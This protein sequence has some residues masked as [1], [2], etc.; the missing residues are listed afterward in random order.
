VVTDW[1]VYVFRLTFPTGDAGTYLVELQPDPVRPRRAI[2]LQLG[3]ASVA[4]IERG[5][6]MAQDQNLIQENSSLWERVQQVIAAV[7]EGK[8][9]E[10]AV[11]EVGVS[12]ELVARLVEMG[13]RSPFPAAELSL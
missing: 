4:E 3:N 12:A 1:G 11:A 7:R 10:A 6:N 8:T 2:A 9:I 13:Q 5:L